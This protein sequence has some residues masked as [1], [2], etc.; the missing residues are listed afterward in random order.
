[1]KSKKILKLI[2]LGCSLSE[3]EENYSIIWNQ[4]KKELEANYV[5]FYSNNQFAYTDNP[6]LGG[7]LAASSQY[8]A[9]P[10]SIYRLSIDLN[11]RCNINCNECKNLDIFPCLAC[12]QTGGNEVIQVNHFKQVVC[13]LSNL[14][15]KELFILGGDQ[16]L[17][18][19]IV[20]EVIYI[21]NNEVKNGNIYI[22]TNGQRIREYNLK[23]LEFLK[24]TN[25]VLIIQLI[26][27]IDYN[28]IINILQINGIK[29]EVVSRNFIADNEIF[30]NSSAL[31]NIKSGNH[32][33]TKKNL[34]KIIGLYENTFYKFRN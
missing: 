8:L 15:L 21:F 29:Y 31:R 34:R 11:N 6:T 25:V 14:G 22:V 24:L 10:P 27:G 19:E 32:L 26:K 2:N 5:I 13:L 16:L 23:Q 20:K 18:F 1:M 3:L 9:K 17:D 12:S 4:F 33:I 7:I 30:N 28:S